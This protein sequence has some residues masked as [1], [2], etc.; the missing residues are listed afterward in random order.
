MFG[1]DDFEQSDWNSEIGSIKLDVEN[2]MGEYFESLNE[3]ATAVYRL[4][5][6]SEI[7][8]DDALDALGHVWAAHACNELPKVFVPREDGVLCEMLMAL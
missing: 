6:R 8:V 5:D 7:T 4:L 1:D 2:A 3:V